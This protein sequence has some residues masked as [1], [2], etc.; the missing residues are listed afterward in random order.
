M[1]DSQ[2][3]FFDVVSI[4]YGILGLATLRELFQ[5][6]DAFWDDTVTAEDRSL[7]G[8]LAFFVLIPIGVLLHEFGHA[9]ATWQVGGHVREFHWRVFWGYIIPDGDFSPAQDWWISLSGNLVSVALGL[10]AIPLIRLPKRRIFREILHTFSKVELVFSL[11]VYPLFS[12]SGAGGDWAMIYDFSVAPY[13]QITL[14]VHLL[15]LFGLSRLERSGLI[16]RWLMA[17][18]AGVATGSP[19][20]DEDEAVPPGPRDAP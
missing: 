19:V 5:K 1:P 10:L 6:W 18:A 2:Y 13:A 9:L 17:P 20:E 7:A 16:Q 14:G 3:V 12:F 11:V 8:R 15:L 4:L